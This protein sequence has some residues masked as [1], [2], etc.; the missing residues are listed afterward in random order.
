MRRKP[1]LALR[2]VQ[3]SLRVQVQVPLSVV[4]SPETQTRQLPPTMPIPSARSRGRMMESRR[5]G[6]LPRT[7]RAGGNSPRK[8]GISSPRSGLLLATHVGA[9]ATNPKR[10]IWGPR[11]A[12]MLWCR[13]QPFFRSLE[14]DRR[15]LLAAVFRVLGARLALVG[16]RT[17]RLALLRAA[18]LALPTLV[19]LAALARFLRL[20]RPDRRVAGQIDRLPI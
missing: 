12:P 15:S 10:R 7:C 17:L 2:S 1:L 8:R 19:A 3:P 20:E 14:T 11:L 6:G 9:G 4:R 5:R 13:G 18:L 16:A